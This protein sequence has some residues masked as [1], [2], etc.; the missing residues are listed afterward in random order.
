MGFLSS[1]P[2]ADITVLLYTHRRDLIM[3]HVQ[4]AE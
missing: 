2:L 4:Y 1:L 3:T